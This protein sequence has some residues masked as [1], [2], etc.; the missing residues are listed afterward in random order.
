M[1]EQTGGGLNI[2]GVFPISEIRTGGHK[3]YIELTRQLVNRGHQVYQLCRP[4]M[5]E[6]LPGVTVPVIP[7]AL[8]GYVV[9]RWWRY[10]YWVKRGMSMIRRCLPAGGA[11][12]VLVFGETNFFAARVVARS[13]GVPLVFALR[14]NFFDEFLTFGT[15]SRRLPWFPALQKRFQRWWKQHLEHAICEGSNMVVF[16][17]AYDRDNVI[18]R[19][20]GLT[21]R[22]VVIPNSFR[23][24]WLP[25]RYRQDV[26]PPVGD[27][28]T[29][30]FIKLLY[31]GHLNERKGIP[32]L[33]PAIK[34]LVA[35]GATSFHLDVVGFGGLEGWSR[36]YVEQNQL[37]E[38]VA[39]HGRVD[40]PLDFLTAADLVIV[41]SVYDSYPNTVLEAFFTGTPVLGADAAGIRDML[42]DPVLLVPHS[43]SEGLALRLQEILTVPDAYARV[44]RAAAVQRSRFDFDWAER[45]EALFLALHAP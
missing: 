37:R 5:A 34:Q 22:T 33:F 1:G 30:E 21:G 44:C 15:S 12:L 13:L 35:A 36:E 9:P 38:W 6:R 23:V 14:S 43:S 20:P 29:P 28:H 7:D 40:D 24:S 42:Q 11:D 10:R 32:F 26:V 4:S 27:A 31:L 19:N 41:P 8:K 25:E 16:Q 45:W 39:F 18:Q 17:T 2:V 3:R